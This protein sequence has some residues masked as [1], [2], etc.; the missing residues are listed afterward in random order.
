[1]GLQRM[2][3][4][5]TPRVRMLNRLFSEGWLAGVGDLD[6]LGCLLTSLSVLCEYTK[7]DALGLRFLM[8]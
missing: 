3:R 6:H 1:M 8:R 5:L 4:M 2:A 7:L